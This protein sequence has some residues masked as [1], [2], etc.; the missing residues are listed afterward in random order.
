MT[1]K[2]RPTCLLQVPYL[3]QARP[4]GRFAAHSGVV[5]GMA[6]GARAVQETGWDAERDVELLLAFLNTVNMTEAT[7]V[8][9]DEQTWRQW[10]AVRGLGR[11]RRS[12]QGPVEQRCLAGRRAHPP[13]RSGRGRASRRHDPRLH[14]D[15][16]QRR[17]PR[18]HRRRRPR[19]RTRRRRP[20]RRARLLG[21]DQ[22]LP[23]R[24]LSLGVLRP[25]PK[26]L[27]HLVLH[28]GLRQPRKG[29]QLAR[30]HPQ[31]RFLTHPSPH[32]SR[33]G[34]PVA[35]LPANIHSRS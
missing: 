25:I 12:P 3:T 24:R 14:P 8:L 22:D 1:C 30:A 32:H 26:P 16:T 18:T 31:R 2:C 19:R 15:R 9:D 34:G 10:A 4:H 6:A 20:T 17:R 33:G 27:A 11:R 7:D 5:T 35:S 29:P 28:A 13:R 23:R 21:T